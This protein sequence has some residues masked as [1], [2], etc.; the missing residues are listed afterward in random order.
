MGRLTHRRM[1]LGCH[2]NMNAGCVYVS[3]CVRGRERKR[4]REREAEA[5]ASCIHVGS[6]SVCVSFW[7]CIS[8]WLYV[9]RTPSF[10]PLF[11]S[12]LLS[13]GK[14]DAEDMKSLSRS[15][16][17][18][19]TPSQH[20]SRARSEEEHNRDIYPVSGV[21]FTGISVPSSVCRPPSPTLGTYVYHLSVLA[22]RNG[23]DF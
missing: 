2:V 12:L 21:L 17:S 8:S 4:E 6:V 11:L 18:T 13:S 23:K 16:R 1:R 19:N 5:G 7:C 9:C 14:W 3:V 22:E 20:H 15:P 10:P